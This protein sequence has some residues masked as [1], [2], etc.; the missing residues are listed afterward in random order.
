MINVIFFIKFLMFINKMTILY[1][2][3]EFIDLLATQKQK[4]KKK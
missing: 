4:N 2:F 1:P 3:I